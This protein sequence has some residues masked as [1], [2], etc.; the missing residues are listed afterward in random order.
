MKLIYGSISV[1]AGSCGSRRVPSQDAAQAHAGGH[2]R[3]PAAEA[4]P[5]ADHD[6]VVCGALYPVVGMHRMVP[7]RCVCYPVACVA[8]TALHASV[9]YS[10]W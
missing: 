3:Q 5:S 10:G 4:L 9:R 7:D 8:I 6:L 1:R 2:E